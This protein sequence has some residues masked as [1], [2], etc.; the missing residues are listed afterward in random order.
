PGRKQAAAALSDSAA[1]YQQ[2]FEQNRAIQLLIDPVTAFIVEA[3]QAAREFYGYDATR[4]RSMT[5]ADIA[6]A[7][8]EEVTAA[9]SRIVAHP[10]RGQLIVQHRLASGAMRD[11]EIH[12]GPVSVR[13]KQLLYSI[14]HDVTERKRTE[15]VLA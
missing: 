1:Q 4:M 6:N 2:M 12:T 14:I 7:P 11:V 9:M 10:Q 13:G 8:L 15:E 3:N 5:I